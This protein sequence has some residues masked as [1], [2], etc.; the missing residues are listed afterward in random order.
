M[1]G[2][3]CK[4]LDVSDSEKVSRAFYAQLGAAGLARR[5]RPEWDEEIL[6]TLVEMLPRHARV[7]DV[8]CGYG[9]I[10]LPLARRGFEV[11]GLDV[12]PNLIEAARADADGLRAGF[13]VGSMTRMPYASASFEGVICLWSTFHELLEEDEQVQAIGEMWRVL[14]PGGFALIEGPVYREPSDAE[15]ESGAR[16]GPDDR[17]TWDL[18][19]GIPHPHYAHDERSFR[20]ICQAGGVESFEVF[21]REWGG[22]QRLF[23][24]V[25]RPA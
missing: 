5:T 1:L 9:R 16:G 6:G 13:V 23:L 15:V 10:A 8:G 20:R 11:E 4:T 22:R 14:R 2:G 3:R 18:V 24:R 19:E 12:A 17:I 7:L 21:E 25:D